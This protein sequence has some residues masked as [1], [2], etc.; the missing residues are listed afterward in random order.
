MSGT[1]VRCGRTGEIEYGT[2][3]QA[4]CS[5]CIFYGLNKQCSR[6]RMYLPGSELQQY[7][8]QLACPYCIQ[9]MRDE[10]RRSEYHE[11]KH[12]LEVLQIPET[13]ERCGRDL[14]GRVYIWN[15]KKLCRN[16]VGDEQEKWGVV[17]G[18]PMGAPQKI[19]LE[20]EKRKRKASFIES[21]ISEVL[22][23]SGVK[24]KPRKTEIVEYSTKM[25]IQYAK[26][27]AEESLK[28]RR[29]ED[30][31]PESEG[32]MKAGKPELE[33]VPEKRPARE[34]PPPDFFEEPQGKKKK[35]P[36]KRGVRKKRAEAEVDL[37]EIF[38]ERNKK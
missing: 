13:C 38:V 15:G 20:P 34:V 10:D 25:P 36:R 9:D 30:K 7:R 1:C 11:E 19:S 14:E 32:I 4:Y 28:T 23:L 26:P 37:S 35:K 2:D 27:M 18:G 5:S 17:G 16:C 8:G 6:C 22:H 21:V 24:K 3:G 12:K 29:K 31:K 33:A